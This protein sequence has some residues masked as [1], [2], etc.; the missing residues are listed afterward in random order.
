MQKNLQTNTTFW[1]LNRHATIAINIFKFSTHS[2]V[3]PA[4]RLINNDWYISKP[5]LFKLHI[6]LK[7]TSQKPIPSP[8]PYSTPIPT[9]MLIT[10]HHISNYHAKARHHINLNWPITMNN[11]NKNTMYIPNSMLIQDSKAYAY[12]PTIYL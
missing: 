5:G 7:S 6:Y 11:H 3:I 1:V 12:L 2:S 9:I 10:S 8:K 4:T